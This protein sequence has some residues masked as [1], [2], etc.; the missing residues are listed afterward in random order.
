MEIC[1]APPRECFCICD[2]RQM[3]LMRDVMQGDKANPKFAMNN[4]NRPTMPLHHRSVRTNIVLK[5]Q[6]SQESCYLLYQLLTLYSAK[7]IIAPHG[8]I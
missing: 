7:I 6:A 2:V 1:V 4:N 3:S 5:S 8:L